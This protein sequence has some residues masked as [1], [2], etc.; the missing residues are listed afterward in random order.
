MAKKDITLNARFS[1]LKSMRQHASQQQS[2]GRDSL[3]AKKRGLKSSEAPSQVHCPLRMCSDNA[4]V[5]Q[6]HGL[7]DYLRTANGRHMSCALR[8]WLVQR[9]SATKR[10]LC[11]C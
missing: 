1:M 5:Q 11:V 6:M 10:Q 7:T 8:A 9:T 4:V 3:L 2:V